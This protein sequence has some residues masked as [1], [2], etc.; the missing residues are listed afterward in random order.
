MMR[1]IGASLC[2]VVAGCVDRTSARAFAAG[3]GT[4]V[5]VDT[6]PIMVNADPPFRYP[7]NLW[8]LR[9]Q[10]NVTLHLFVDSLGHVVAESTRVA[11][12][13]GVLA[14]DAAA[15]TGA[16]DLVFTAARLQGRPVGVALQLP[17]FFRHPEAAPLPGDSA[18]KRI[19]QQA[20]PR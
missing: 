20:D 5:A 6:A 8:A 18:I 15:L 12:S 4:P 1:A 17:V 7:A 3:V 19:N 16:R 10:G 11:A 13:S 14:L 2:V 9:V